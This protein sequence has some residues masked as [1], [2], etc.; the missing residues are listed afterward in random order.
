MLASVV[1][2]IFFDACAY[3]P[4]GLQTLN[5]IDFL[6]M[7]YGTSCVSLQNFKRY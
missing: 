5:V 7:F 1:L 4:V 2:A 6:C 3:P